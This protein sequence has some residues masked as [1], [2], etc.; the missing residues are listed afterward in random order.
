[1]DCR[2]KMSQDLHSLAE[3]KYSIAILCEATGRWRIQHHMI[4]IMIRLVAYSQYSMLNYFCHLG[5]QLGTF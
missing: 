4:L 3:L 5:R 1:M 2:Y